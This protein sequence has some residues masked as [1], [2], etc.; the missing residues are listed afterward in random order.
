MLLLVFSLLEACANEQ[1]TPES[2]LVTAVAETELREITAVSP[3][4]T[5][6]PLPTPSATTLPTLTPSQIPPTATATPRPIIT[7]PAT[8][9]IPSSAHFEVV[10][11]IGGAV[12]A[13]TV[14]GNY[15][16]AGIGARLAIIE[17]SDP[18][19]PIVIYWSG[20]LP[21]IVEQL[22][23][24]NNYL[25][26]A[27]G[28]A[29]FWIFKVTDAES[30]SLVGQVDTTNPARHFLLADNLAYVVNDFGGE[31]RTNEVL[32]IVDVQNPSNPEQISSFPLPTQ[33]KRLVMV[34]NYLYVAIYPYYS[35]YE[36]T[37][38]VLDVSDPLQPGLVTAIPELAG[39]D[40]L[41]A[42]DRLFIAEDAHL[43]VADVQNPTNP[44]LLNQ[45]PLL[46]DYANINAIIQNGDTIFALNIFGDIGYCG[47]RLFSFD[48]SNLDEI[49]QLDV[50][51]TDCGIY[52]MTIANNLLFLATDHALEIIDI[53][54]PSKISNIGEL[55]TLPPFQQI[56]I[57]DH[58]FGLGR[59][60]NGY[61]LFS[62]DIANP[63]N[64]K[65]LSKFGVEYLVND[66]V[67]QDSRLYLATYWQGIALLDMS[68][69]DRPRITAVTDPQY[70]AENS[71]QLVLEDEQLFASLNGHLGIFSLETLD[72]FGGDWEEIGY[73]RYNNFM[74]DENILWLLKEDSIEAIDVFDPQNITPI[75]EL[76]AGS[77][78]NNQEINSQAQYLY[79]LT[80]SYCRPEDETIV[81]SDR[82]LKLFNITDPANIF[83]V[84]S[85]VIPEEINQITEYGDRLIL[86]GEDLW[87]VDIA[88]PGQPQI[89]DQF[90]TPGYADNVIIKGDLIYVA[91]RTGGLL[92]L[93]LAE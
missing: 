15:A 62:L 7:P 14:Q 90:E 80:G 36:N 79:Q 88:N 74:I 37:L 66:F 58:L 55:E 18:K 76:V 2:T 6:S 8:S 34:N 16:F 26:A 91:D 56:Q 1:P 22:E 19:N 73:G 38:W 51:E 49:Q 9:L 82:E 52:D 43:M 31:P 86:S 12:T 40:M 65:L 17:V 28:N 45:S 44:L 24:R 68:N 13:V 67:A 48:I 42:E 60:G 78:E 61:E 29:G 92:I 77:P 72:W 4:P 30:L 23:F 47:T 3:T 27:L 53:H 87:L 41:L 33:A 54:D 39:Q 69:L 5:S 25:Y 21:G 93:W 75:S 70:H 57:G 35:G 32:S 46:I 11:Q 63:E 85:I 20:I 71:Y 64:P 59:S 84:S 50:V 89:I 10:N 83:F 81:C